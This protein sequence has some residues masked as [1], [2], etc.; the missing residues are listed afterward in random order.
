MNS[1]TGK[2]ELTDADPITND[3]W[4]CDLNLGDLMA[5]YRIPSEYDDAVISD[6]LV[7]SMIEVNRQLEPIKTLLSATY[8]DLEAY[9]T[10]NSEQTGGVEVV[11]KK[12][13]EA[14]YCYAKAIL[15]QQFKTMNRK[16]E[17]E[18]IAKEAQETEHY[19]LNRSLQAVLF[20]FKK[21]SIDASTLQS[22]N[23]VVV[24]AI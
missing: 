8:S 20:F 11:V 21:F 15:L 24:I 9:H 19:W 6:G 22:V 12:Y 3:G 10:V 18:N 17:A 4:W 7:L 2:P 1:F 13:E 16:A 5:Q 23:D 14:V